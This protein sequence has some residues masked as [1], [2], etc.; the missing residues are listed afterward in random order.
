MCF[1]DHHIRILKFKELKM[2]FAPLKL[3]NTPSRKRFCRFK[4]TEFVF[5]FL[6]HKNHIQWLKKLIVTQ[7]AIFFENFAETSQKRGVIANLIELHNQKSL[8]SQKFVINDQRNP[9]C[10]RKKIKF[11]VSL[12]FLR[13]WTKTPT[14][15]INL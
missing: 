9:W 7:S 10:P 3:Q 13:G 1:L 11:T 2:N 8:A 6:D 14:S 5:N 12:I 4:G 15:N